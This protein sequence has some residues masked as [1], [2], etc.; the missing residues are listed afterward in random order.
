MPGVRLAQH[1]D[2]SMML[3][4]DPLFAWRRNYAKRTLRPV[5]VAV[6]GDSIAFGSG[7]AV[8]SAPD[9]SDYL[10]TMIVQL[11]RYLN[12]AP[13]Y[14]LRADETQS[15]AGASY[16]PGVGGGYCVPTRLQGQGIADPWRVAAGTVTSI[17]RGMGLRSLQINAASRLA[18]TAPSANAF[19]WWYEDGAS[20]LGTPAVSIYAGDYNA[21][22]TGRQVDNYP[23]T[24]NTGLAQYTRTFSGIMLPA[25]GRYTVEFS[26]SSGTP[27]LDMLYVADNDLQS[28]V[29]VYNYAFGSQLSTNFADSSTAAT[30]AA[31]ASKSLQAFGTSGID[32]I[33]IYLGANDYA[34]DVAPATFQANLEAIVDKYRAAQ[35][36]PQAF[37]IVSHFARYDKASPVYPWTQYQTAMKNV[38]STRTQVDYLDLAPWFPASQAADTDDDLVDT[39]G[40]HLTAAGQSIAAQAIANK[41]SFPG[42][43]V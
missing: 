25:R 33:V 35:T 39:S 3:T 41:L 11:S 15:P 38:T 20:N 26:P 10:T 9:V 7:T 16:N 31:T 42:G 24:M 4:T 30:T 5:N 28:G 32:L 8:A 29:R 22:R 21:N 13:P 43:V 6:I 19:F 2:A 18:F 1:L 34:N 27:V 23:M 40:V 37:L 12:Q 36:R 14:G 17:S